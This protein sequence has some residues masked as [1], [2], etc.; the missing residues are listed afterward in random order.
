MNWAARRRAIYLLGVAI[1]FLIVV[2]GPVAYWYLTIPATC[3]DGIRNQDETSV[4]RGGSCP[5]LDERTLQPSATMWS[6]SFRVRDGFYNAVAYIQN[7]N[8]DAGVRRARYRFGLYDTRNILIAERTGTTFIVPG[9]ITP[10]LEPRI[11][12]G[13]R[14]VSRT[15]FELEEGLLWERLENPANV[16][17]ITSRDVSNVDAAPRVS[18]IVT[19]ESVSRVEEP[20][21]VVVVFDQAGNAFAA[22]ATQISALDG[23]KKTDI[24]FSWPDPF[25]FAVSKIDITPLVTPVPS[26]SR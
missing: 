7:P 14:V 9:G 20:S 4:D 10:V 24:V 22:S 2:G 18:A 12:T 3:T 15:Y 5:F 6:R 16:L 1:F 8:A 23:G 19:N 11:D 13:N 17:T 25:P 21:F 26:R